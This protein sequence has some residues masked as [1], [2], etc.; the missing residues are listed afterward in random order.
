MSYYRPTLRQTYPITISHGRGALLFDPSGRAYLDFLGANGAISLG[1]SH[2]A[3]LEQARQQLDRVWLCADIPTVTQEQTIAEINAVLPSELGL[4]MLYSTGSEAMELALRLSR[5]HVGGRRFL[6]FK[7]HFHGKTQ[8]LI[9]L[10]SWFPECYGPAPTGYRTAIELDIRQGHADA[11]DS[12]WQAL[13]REDGPDVAGVICEPVI[14][15][16]GPRRLPETFLPTLRRFCDARGVPLIVDEIL[17]GLFRCEGWFYSQSRGVTPDILC[18]GKGL[19]NGLPISA[20]A[21]TGAIARHLPDTVAGSTFSGSGVSCAAAL[22]VLRFLGSNDL[23]KHVRSLEHLFFSRLDAWRQ[24]R[25]YALELDGVGAL[26]SLRLPSDDGV[27]MDEL[28]G[29]LL[30][31]GLLV[32]RGANGLRVIPPLTISWAEMQRGLEILERCLD[33]CLE[34]AAGS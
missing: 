10:L 5:A 13:W 34:A 14:G 27:L 22:G 19:A 17:C 4:G 32:S 23:E 7:E 18:F 11:A 33:R 29:D 2:P 25:G 31:Q 9:Q 28:Y 26:L 8:G 30:E 1:H 12:L 16:S 6:T 15:S 20:I 24:R 21:V 3:V